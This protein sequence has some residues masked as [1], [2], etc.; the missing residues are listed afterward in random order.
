M[1]TDARSAFA[2]T[3]VSQPPPRSTAAEMTARAM[4]RSMPDSDGT[5][6]GGVCRHSPY[7]A[8]R[9]SAMAAG[10]G[11][12]KHGMRAS[13]AGA[14][15]LRMNTPRTGLCGLCLAASAIAAATSSASVTSGGMKITITA[16][17][18]ASCIRSRSASP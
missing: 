13:A 5:V 4:P 8:A 9:A 16:L 11:N 12:E 2:S 14:A 7:A 6:P 3:A 10:S 18:L 15:P 1:P 17:T